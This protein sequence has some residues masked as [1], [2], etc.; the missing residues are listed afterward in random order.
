M[1]HHRIWTEAPT[2]PGEYRELIAVTGN[3]YGDILLTLDGGEVWQFTPNKK[4]KNHPV[5]PE[6][7]GGV[8]YGKDPC[9]PL[10]GG[11]TEEELVTH[12]W[13][14]SIQLDPRSK[15]FQVSEIRGNVRILPAPEPV[16]ATAESVGKDKPIKTKPPKRS[17]GP[18]VVARAAEAHR[19]IPQKNL[20]LIFEIFD[21]KSGSASRRY[22]LTA[23][24]CN[25]EQLGK[26]GKQVKPHH[27][28]YLIDNRTP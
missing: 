3:E 20:F 10:P 26:P 7:I 5:K 19:I 2:K 13:P 12:V 23:D 22:Q 25:R 17:R 14:F 28:R 1:K 24:Q 4:Q 18:E 21:S 8:F 6:S 9:G 15:D 27:I 11:E 16:A